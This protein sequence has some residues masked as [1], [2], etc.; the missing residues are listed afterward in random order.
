VHLR[1]KETIRDR[2]MVISPI[3]VR[4]GVRA[5]VMCDFQRQKRLD[6]YSMY[7]PDLTWEVSK[8]FSSD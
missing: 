8:A 4:F 7:V 2:A 1:V 3:F 6:S 5:I